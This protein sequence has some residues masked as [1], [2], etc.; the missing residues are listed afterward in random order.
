M[1]VNQNNQTFVFKSLGVFLVGKKKD[2]KAKYFGE[3]NKGHKILRKGGVG[4]GTINKK[5]RQSTLSKCQMETL[6]KRDCIKKNCIC[7]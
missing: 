4:S 2:R 5:G 6:V 7:M 3:K 1:R